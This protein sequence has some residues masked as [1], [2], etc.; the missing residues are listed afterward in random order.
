MKSFLR[1]YGNAIIQLLFH[2]HGLSRDIIDLVGLALLVIMALSFRL[3]LIVTLPVSAGILAFRAYNEH[4][5]DIDVEDY[6][7]W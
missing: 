6:L 7:G 4:Q 3:L 5:K 1:F 2:W